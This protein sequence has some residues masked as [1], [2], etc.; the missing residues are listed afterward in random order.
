MDV[1]LLR[2]LQRYSVQIPE[3]QWY[4]EVGR[5][6]ELLFDK[7]AVLTSLEPYY[8]ADTGLSLDDE[9]MLETLMA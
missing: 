5:T 6:L 3:R 2:Q 8:S 9:G 1:H 4:A 7:Y